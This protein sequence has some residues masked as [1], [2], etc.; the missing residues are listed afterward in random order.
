MDQILDFLED[1]NPLHLLLELP[2]S[3]DPGFQPEPI[4]PITFPCQRAV[5]TV[6]AS[7]KTMHVKL[8]KIDSH[9]PIKGNNFHAMCFPQQL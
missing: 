4:L 5:Q 9:S 7:C 6:V 8:T 2:G 1:A 3:V